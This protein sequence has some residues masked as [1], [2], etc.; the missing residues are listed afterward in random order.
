[1]ITEWLRRGTGNVFLGANNLSIG[2]NGRSAVFSGVIQDGGA[3]GGT[4]GSLTKTGSG[5]L[6]LSNANFYTGGTIVSKG[7]LIMK[8]TTGS[9]T[10]P[11]A[12]H[13][14]GGTLGGTGIIGGAVTIGNGTSSGA[15]LQA[16]SGTTAGTLKINHML[17]FNS[18]SAY[19][20]VLNRKATPVAGKVSAQGVTIHTNVPFT[21]VETGTATLTAGT[22]FT[23][24]NNTSG[25]PISGRFSNLANGASFTSGGTTYK[26]NYFGG[27]G[28]DLTLTVVP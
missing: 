3:N 21:F 23:I 16:G 6:T 17:T 13:V 9:A 22:V 11:G 10:G 12:V 4:G 7:S 19:K 2:S 15:I 14:N 18:L 8:N 24:I 5:T 26:A 28:N 20:C 25:N 27:T 1:L